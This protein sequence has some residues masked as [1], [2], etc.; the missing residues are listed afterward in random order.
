M[1]KLFQIGARNIFRNKRRMKITILV[2]LIGVIVSTMLRGFISAIQEEFIE[3]VTSS[4]TGD[5]QL[6][7]K[8]YFNAID[9]LPLDLTINDRGKEISLLKESP[10]VVSFTPRL[11]FNGILSSGSQNTLFIAMAF[12]PGSVLSVCPKIVDTIKA[13]SFIS[14]HE[15]NKIVISEQLAD[16]LGIGLNDNLILLAKTRDGI[17][18]TTYVTIGGIFKTMILGDKHLIY[19]NIYM[20]RELLDIGDESTE[21]AIKIK[22]P[23]QVGKTKSQLESSFNSSGLAVE[24]KTWREIMGFFAN[25]MNIQNV[26]NIVIIVILFAL[27]TA[28]IIN[29][30]LMTVYERTKEIG[31]M[32]AIGMKAKQVKQLFLIEGFYYGLIGGILGNLITFL[33]MFLIKLKG[34]INYTLASE[35]GAAK[36]WIIFPN[37]SLAFRIFILVF[38]G[39]CGMIASLYPARKASKMRIV[40]VLH[41]KEL[42][43]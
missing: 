2:I 18:N 4:Q 36:P 28:T 23:K 10:G 19:T 39:V 22:N 8:N 25:V 1:I 35:M 5:L 30:V 32:R 15:P 33:I 27:V 21:I 9:V 31:V 12:D 26:F 34:G 37:V 13:G 40:D 14:Q 42:Y 20:A 43:K 17:L 6:F 29:T 38:A 11:K 16:S 41:E 3:S 7:R 24:V